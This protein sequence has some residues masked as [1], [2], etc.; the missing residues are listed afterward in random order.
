MR[1]ERL[2]RDARFLHKSG[3]SYPGS[4]R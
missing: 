2:G 4:E 1:L 3:D